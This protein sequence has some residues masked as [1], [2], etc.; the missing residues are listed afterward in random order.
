MRPKAHDPNPA[1]GFARKCGPSCEGLA[2]G[3]KACPIHFPRVK[4]QAVDL[5]IPAVSWGGK[6]W[7]VDHQSAV[8]IKEQVIKTWISGPNK[9]H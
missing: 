7:V 1:K 6:W 9:R 3:R 5:S 4:V 8:W 2:A